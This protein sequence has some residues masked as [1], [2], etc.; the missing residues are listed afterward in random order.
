M[1]QFDDP[2]P[3]DGDYKWWITTG[4]VDWGTLFD[5]N[6]PHNRGQNRGAGPPDVDMDPN[7][8]DTG[9]Y[10]PQ[11]EFSY[12]DWAED[13]REE[14]MDAILDYKGYWGGDDEIHDEADTSPAEH[15]YEDLDARDKTASTKSRLCSCAECF[16]VTQDA[17]F[18]HPCSTAGCSGES[19]CQVV[20]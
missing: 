6:A 19:A 12:E 13:N 9:K 4:S 7:D 17:T 11:D 18:C 16:D 10:G 15:F 2:D 8:W 20:V 14:V 3:D 5:P 1:G